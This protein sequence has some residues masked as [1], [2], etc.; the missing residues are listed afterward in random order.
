M[1]IEVSNAN[2]RV[3]V[4]ILH[5]SGD[6]DMSTAMELQSKAEELIRAGASHVLLDLTNAPYVSSA[7]FRT[8][9][10]LYN[11]LRAL[12]PSANLTDEQVRRG[13]S[14]GTYMSP[15]LKLL[16]LSDETRKVFQMTGFDM[17]IETYNDLKEAIAAF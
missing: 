17:Y 1:I 5:I 6:L 3:P 14:E 4:T 13:V 10:S 11:Q 16:N 12:H 15:H 9:H 7:G 2:G 8:I